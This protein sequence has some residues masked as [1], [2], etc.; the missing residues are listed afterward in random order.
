MSSG[1]PQNHFQVR[2]QEWVRHCFGDEIANNIKERNLRFLEE[3]LE[4]VQSLGM[5]KEQAHA[6]VDYVYGRDVGEPKQEAGGVTV[7]LMSLGE[8]NGIQVL[9]EAEKEL[10]RVWG[11]VDR[12]R[13]KQAM[14]SGKGV[15]VE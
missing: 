6:M 10:A 1:L 2:V 14:K 3:A 12:I 5:T 4:L 8:A 13:E 15:A 7:T 9:E 11:N